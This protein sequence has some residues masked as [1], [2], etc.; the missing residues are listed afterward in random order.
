MNIFFF[1]EWLRRMKKSEESKSS[2]S[3]M[4]DE[5]KNAVFEYRVRGELCFVALLIIIFML[6][7]M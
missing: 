6:I 3:P 7:F 1:Q 2:Q 5:N 4:T